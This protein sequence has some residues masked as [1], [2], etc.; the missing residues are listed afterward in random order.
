MT[1][2][3]VASWL[4]L[5]TVLP[6]AGV[7]CAASPYGDF[8]RVPDRDSCTLD[9]ALP[10]MACSEACPIKVREA[11][12]GVEGVQRVDVDYDARR[13]SVE[14]VYPACSSDGFE[15]MMKNLYARGYRARV[16]SARRGFTQPVP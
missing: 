7:S 13:A 8:S 5:L 3:K 2:A 10:N 11:I 12:G 9:V 14:A 4:C 1:P 16:I 15:E 6:F